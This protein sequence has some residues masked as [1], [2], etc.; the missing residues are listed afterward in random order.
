MANTGRCQQC[1]SITYSCD[2]EPVMTAVCHCHDCQRQAGA[3]SSILVAVPAG[4]LAISG[5]TLSSFATIGD[6]HGTKTN[7]HFCTACGSPI[8]SRVEAMPGIAFITAGTLDDTS[9]LQP[10][11]EFYGRSAQAWEPPVPGPQRFETVP[12]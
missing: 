10:A 3:A 11:M 5:D 4:I 8:V 6:A 9:W 12:S 7:R 1:G 2:A